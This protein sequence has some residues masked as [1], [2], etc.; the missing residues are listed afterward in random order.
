M[1]LRLFSFRVQEYQDKTSRNQAEIDFEYRKL[2]I[3][4]QESTL[5]ADI[6]EKIRRQLKITDIITL[7]PVPAVLPEIT[8][9][10]EKVINNAVSSLSPTFDTF[11]GLRC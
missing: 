4:R 9:E 8:E 11:D 10:M 7:E 3:L 6:A 5:N 2:D 1:I